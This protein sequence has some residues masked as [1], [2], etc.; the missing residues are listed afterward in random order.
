MISSYLIHDNR[1]YYP[2]TH[3][4]NSMRA[5]ALMQLRN[6]GTRLSYRRIAAN[7]DPIA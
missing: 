3:V 7:V 2:R 5:K 1:R 4:R 6:N